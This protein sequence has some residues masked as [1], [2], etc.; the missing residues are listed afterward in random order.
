MKAEIVFSSVHND[1]IT[2]EVSKEDYH[3]LMCKEI[4][5]VW[6]S[7]KPLPSDVGFVGE[8]RLK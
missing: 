6:V 8:F 2:I 4:N 5:H 7:R 1:V 3:Q